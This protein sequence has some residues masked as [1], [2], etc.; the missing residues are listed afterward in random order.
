MLRPVEHY[1][2]ASGAKIDRALTS[3]FLGISLHL[4]AK[5]ELTQDLA[6]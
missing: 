3:I 6:P 5:I 1:D 2:T 4:R